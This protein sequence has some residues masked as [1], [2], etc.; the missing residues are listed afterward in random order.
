MTEHYDDLETR[1]PEARKRAQFAA[2]PALI[3]L[4]KEKAPGFAARSI[5]QRSPIGRRWRSCR[6]CA[7]AS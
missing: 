3:R 7:R 1:T 2:L 5:P 4:A 6:S